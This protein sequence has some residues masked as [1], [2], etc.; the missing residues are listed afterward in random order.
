M[1]EVT[2]M[3]SSNNNRCKTSA[4]EAT[5]EVHLGV[6][7]AH[8]TELFLLDLVMVPFSSSNNNNNNHSSSSSSRG[9][10]PRLCMR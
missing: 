7:Q 5:L 6:D 2:P 1:R 4:P 9:T 10:V 3:P 8:K